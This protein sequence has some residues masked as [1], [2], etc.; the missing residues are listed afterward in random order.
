MRDAF[1]S[2]DP[3]VPPCYGFRKKWLFA[4]WALERQDRRLAALKRIFF[5]KVRL[6]AHLKPSPISNKTE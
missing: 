1:E 4:M 6:V 2:F 3:P 5:T